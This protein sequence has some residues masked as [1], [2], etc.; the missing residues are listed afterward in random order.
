MRI[1]IQIKKA[2]IKNQRLHCIRLQNINSKV[3]FLR[4][5]EIFL[6]MSEKIHA[7]HSHQ[8]TNTLII[9]IC[10][11]SEFFVEVVN[12]HEQIVEGDFDHDV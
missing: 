6:E 2:N 9:R 7:Q 8:S 12:H 4:R 11:D 3:N 10:W 1:G 5:V